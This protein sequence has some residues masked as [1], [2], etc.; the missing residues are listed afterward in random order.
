VPHAL[1]ETHIARSA[2]DVWAEVRVFEDM[3][4]YPGIESCR[5][6]GDL[7]V[8]T[9]LGGLECD[10]LLVEHDDAARTYTYAVLAFRGAT[11][12][13]LGGGTRIDL[14]SMSGHHRARMA[15]LPMDETTCRVTYELEL[16]DGHDETFDLTSGQYQAVIE[17]LK[18]LVEG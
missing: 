14:D 5:R 17:H 8:A 6:D 11:V 7:R 2:D 4:W 18:A 1:V 15:V 13:D 16:D 3:H 12:I 9:M 10:E